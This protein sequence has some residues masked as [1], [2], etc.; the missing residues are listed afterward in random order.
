MTGGL[1]QHITKNY[2][3][4][5]ELRCGLISKDIL[6]TWKKDT[7]TSLDFPFVEFNTPQE[8]SQWIEMKHGVLM[9]QGN[10]WAVT[11]F[12]ISEDSWIDRTY[13]KCNQD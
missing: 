3:W 2:I 1:T 10:Y 12:S 9:S 4:Q 8:S 13:L 11:H 6:L 7:D 5:I